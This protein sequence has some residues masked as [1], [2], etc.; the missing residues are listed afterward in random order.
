M[1]S[2]PLPRDP[3]AVSL[4]IPFWAPVPE[5]NEKFLHDH[6]DPFKAPITMSLDKISPLEEFSFQRPF[7]GL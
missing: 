1:A 6:Y 7:R 5:T 2:P 3:P 4:V